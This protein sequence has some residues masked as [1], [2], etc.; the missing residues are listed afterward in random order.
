MTALTKRHPR[1]LFATLMLGQM[2]QSL[3]FTAFV[4]ALPSMARDWGTAGPFLAQMTMALGA[5]G[6]MAGSFMSGWL[7]ER[8]GIRRTLIG[9]LLGFTIAGAEGLVFTSAAMMLIAR[10]LIGLAASFLATACIW[11]ISA[12]YVGSARAKVLGVSAA[13][14]NVVAFGAT[15]GGGYLA[16]TYGWHAAFAQFP[17]Y[18]VFGCVLA[19]FSIEQAYP[20]QADRS[21]PAEPYL[22]ALGPFFL[23]ATFLFSVRFMASTQLPF[24]LDGHG[25]HQAEARAVFISAVTVSATLMSLMYGALQDWLSLDGA[26]IVGLTCMGTSLLSFAEG[27]SYGAALAGCLLMGGA[28][29]VLGPYVYHVVAERTD[30]TAR[31]R[32]LGMVSAFSF[33]G[34][35]LNPVVGTFVADLL[36][37]HKLLLLTAA[38]VGAITLAAVLKRLIPTV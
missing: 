33:L 18:G 36:G 11:G 20:R 26:Q 19:Y 27:N 13:L 10:F 2:S 30:A 3:A 32:A 7:L 14:S 16:Q 21:A 15:L 24:I 37:L 29:G 22:R 1:S 12:Q 34:G 9:S 4:A 8:C 38:T 6:M 23:F 28:T 25:I 31:S 5:L 17:L 35:F